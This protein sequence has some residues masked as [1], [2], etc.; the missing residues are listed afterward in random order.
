[1]HLNC[2]IPG[3]LNDA[4]QDVHVLIPRMCDCYSIGQRDFAD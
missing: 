1:M 3:W 2:Y 4:P